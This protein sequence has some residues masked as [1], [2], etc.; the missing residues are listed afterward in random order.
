MYFYKIR[1][2]KLK[3]LNYCVYNMTPETT[4]DT[5]MHTGSCCPPSVV[6]RPSNRLTAT[7]KHGG[8]ASDEGQKSGTCNNTFNNKASTLQKPG[9]VDG[10]HQNQRSSTLS[11]GVRSEEQY[12]RSTASWHPEGEHEVEA[13][14][15]VIRS[16]TSLQH[17]LLLVTSCRSDVYGCLA[18][19]TY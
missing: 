5:Q 3:T 2:K 15:S 7:I 1:K 13:S 10:R 19:E 18:I 11:T 16:L 4:S 6:L 14:K 9:G 12:T 17:P 8:Y